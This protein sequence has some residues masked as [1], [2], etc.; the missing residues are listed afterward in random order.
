M[1]WW[2]GE[3]SEDAKKVVKT[4]RNLDEQEI[5]LLGQFRQPTNITIDNVLY[6][7]YTLRDTA[8]R[9]EPRKYV[10]K[11]VRLAKDANLTNIPN[12]LDIIYNGLDSELRR[13]IRRPKASTTLDSFL[14]NFDDVKYNWQIYIS[15]YRGTGNSKDSLAIN[16][17]KNNRYQNCSQ[18]NIR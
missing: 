17:L 5:K 4:R 8:N 15:R 14:G 3:L 18:Y 16:R 9:R 10:S 7:R 1:N 13:N 6:K 12:Q 2:L 11:I